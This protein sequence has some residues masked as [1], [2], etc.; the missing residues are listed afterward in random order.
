M[1]GQSRCSVNANQPSLLSAVFR[2]SQRNFIVHYFSSYPNVIFQKHI[3][4]VNL[5]SIKRPI[6]LIPICSSIIPCFPQI[7]GFGFSISAL[8]S[9]SIK[10][11]LPLTPAQPLCSAVQQPVVLSSSL[12]SSS[13][14]Q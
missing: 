1:P 9:T 14:V 5:S 11:G 13:S 10:L 3:F 12:S 7:P 4:N 2:L 6:N 8:S